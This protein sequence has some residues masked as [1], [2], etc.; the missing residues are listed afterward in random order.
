MNAKLEALD[1]LN[2]VCAKLRLL[3]VVDYSDLS[4]DTAS[5]MFHL[6]HEIV[7]QIESSSEQLR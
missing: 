5:G 6:L 7:G 2:N 1:R 3:S 4:S